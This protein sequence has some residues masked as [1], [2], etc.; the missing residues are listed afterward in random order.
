[1]AEQIEMLFA[2]CECGEVYLL[3]PSHP[4]VSLTSENTCL[5]NKPNKR[6]MLPN[7]IPKDIPTLPAIVKK[8]ND[9][10]SDEKRYNELSEEDKNLI[11]R[12]ECV[13]LDDGK[14]PAIYH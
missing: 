7:V 11:S 2:P 14:Y 3:L 6:F 13:T 8:F 10:L 9:N 1:M 12:E 4:H 5:W